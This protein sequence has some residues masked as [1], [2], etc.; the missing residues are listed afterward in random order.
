MSPMSS[1]GTFELNENLPFARLSAEKRF[2]VVILSSA[3]FGFLVGV[4][5]STWQLVAESSQVLAG[6]AKY[7]TANPFYIYHLKSWT[8]LNQLGVLDS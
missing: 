1:R 6:I 5:H 2:L 8:I 3:F 4:A 7:P